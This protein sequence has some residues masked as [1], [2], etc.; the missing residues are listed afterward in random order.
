MGDILPDPA[1]ESIRRGSLSVET[2]EL[3]RSI[4]HPVSSTLGCIGGHLVSSN[5][6]VCIGGF[7]VL[8]VGAVYFR[9]VVG[10]FF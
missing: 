7:C 8:I 2:A 5:V 1:C 10:S 4:S 3:D 9:V 6:R